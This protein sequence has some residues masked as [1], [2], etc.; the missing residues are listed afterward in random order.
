MKRIIILL[1]VSYL[2]GSMVGQELKLATIFSD[3]MVLQQQSNVPIWGW[4]KKGTK[5]TVR[6]SWDSKSYETITNHEGKWN[7]N[8]STPKAG[9][10][11]AITVKGS[12][13][14]ELSNI[15]IGE[16]WLA[17]GQSNMSMPLKG[18][19]HQPINGS[20]KAI[21]SAKNKNI[22][23]LNVPPLAAYKQLDNIENTKWK[24]ADVETAGEC[25]AVAW[26]FANLIN[27]QLE[28]PIGII[29]ASF[30]GSNVEA[31]MSADA[32][33]KFE[34]IEIP[35]L[36]DET[37][38]S[39]SGVP[40][41]LYNGMIHPIEGY[42]IRGVIWYQ[43]ES[44]VFNV[45]RYASSVAAMVD[46]WRKN[47]EI[48]E[49]PFLFAQ[50]APY[51]YKEWNFFQPQWP[52]I[53]AYLREAQMKSQSL[54][55]NS[56][57]AVLMDIGE[58]FQIHPARK[59]EVGERLGLLALNK[60]YN[61]KAFESQ[62]PEYD[63]MEIEGDKAIIHFKNQFMGLTSFGKKLELFEIAGENKIFF[64]A[65]AY[66]N[67]EHG[68]VVVSSKY[69]KEPKSVRYAFKN[70][71]KGELFGSGGLPVSSFRTDEW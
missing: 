59:E 43:G 56:A 67:E 50:I 35:Q 16:V 20:T 36:S 13:E 28:V 37:S 38:P 14:I 48:G 66:I 29:N 4:D 53:S 34:D 61:L 2:T 22:H 47:W 55:P 69:V 49:F 26:F 45:P 9:V 63:K 32:C 54:I 12:K 17:S 31:W 27:Q 21:L 3:N 65:D 10:S 58:E 1:I 57:M 18:Y 24:I 23:F 51:E 15:L 41:L 33:K 52:E 40:T 5:I 60:V 30:G 46:S 44:N 71:V 42:T 8:V 7:I 70:Y 25:S 68:T 64:K 62:S 11:Y 6:T 39:I 19:H